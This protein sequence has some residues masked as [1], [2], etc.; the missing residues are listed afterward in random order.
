MLPRDNTILVAR[1]LS[2]DNPSWSV[3]F[4][5]DSLE[6]LGANILPSRGRTRKPNIVGLSDFD[7]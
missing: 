1:E 4:R 3:T 2:G 6:K 7:C 5:G